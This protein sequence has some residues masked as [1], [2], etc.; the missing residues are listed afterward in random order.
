MQLD[1]SGKQKVVHHDT[2]KP[3]V[4]EQ[5]LP[6]AKSALRVHR[7]KAKQGPPAQRSQ[8]GEMHVRAFLVPLAR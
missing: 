2:L 7:T 8:D 6:G 3:Y 5:G 1:A 4:G